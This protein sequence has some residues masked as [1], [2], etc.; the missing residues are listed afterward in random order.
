M[1]LATG[2]LDDEHQEVILGA[3]EIADRTVAEVMTPRPDVRTIPESSTVGMTLDEMNH[4]GFSRLPV[5]DDDG[6]LDTAQGVVALQDVVMADRIEPVRPYRRE[7]PTFPE[8]VPVLVALRTLQ[9]ERQQ[10]AFVVDDSVQASAVEATLREAGGEELVSLELFDVYRGGQLG[11]GR[12]S[13]AY[14][15]RL[16]AADHTMTDDEM[17]QIRQRCIDAVEGAHAATLRG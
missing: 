1:I 17:G 7:A 3:F 16:Q 4:S 8:S 14:A 11:E 15:L 13:L 10:L 12:R 9:Q 5:V 6:G 2:R